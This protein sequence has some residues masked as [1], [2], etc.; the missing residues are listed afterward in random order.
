MRMLPNRVARDPLP[1]PTVSRLP[2]SL[3]LQHERVVAGVSSLGELCPR[4]Q[5]RFAVHV[6]LAGAHRDRLGAVD[7][8]LVRRALAP[9]GDDSLV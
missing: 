1:L 2:V 6:E 9:N 4:W 7:G 8:Q 5:A 3:V